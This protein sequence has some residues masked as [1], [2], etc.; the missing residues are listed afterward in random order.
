MARLYGRALYGQRLV[1]AIP[2]H[3]H[4]STVLMG[5]RP[6]GI[7]VMD[8][9]SAHKIAG[10]QEAIEVVGARVRYLP[11]YLS[12]L[13]P[14]ENLFSKFKSQLRSEAARTVS[15]LWKTAGRLVDRFTAE[16]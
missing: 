13:N 3:W 10:V 6:E 9:L 1:D 12:H 2:G 4:T 15:E 8:N 5:I 14:I 11:P 7:V 16:E